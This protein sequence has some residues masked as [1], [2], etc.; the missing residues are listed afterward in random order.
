MFLLVEE[1]EV[2]AQFAIL[3]ESEKFIS[4]LLD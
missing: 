3:S 4:G 1:W 2:S